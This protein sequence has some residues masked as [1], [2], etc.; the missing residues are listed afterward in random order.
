MSSSDDDNDSIIIQTPFTAD[1]QDNS[2]Y[3]ESNENMVITDTDNLSEDFSQSSSN[4]LSSDHEDTPSLRLVIAQWTVR[5]NV[6]QSTVNDLLHS[7]SIFP[8][9]QCLPKDART[10]LNTPTMVSVK[11]VKGGIYHHFSIK[12]ENT[13][14]MKQ[15]IENLPSILYF[16]VGIDGL[17]ITNNPVSQLWPIL[18]YFSNI[19]NKR[20]QVF[21]IGAIYGKS[22]PLDSNEFVNKI[23]DLSINGFSFNEKH[24]KVTFQGLICDAPAKSFVLNIKGHNGKNSC[25][26]CLNVG[27][28]MN[29][30]VYFPDLESPLRTYTDFLTYKDQT[31]HNGETILTEIPNFNVIDSTPFDYMHSI[32]IGLMKKLLFWTGIH[33]HRQSLPSNLISVLDEKLTS[34][35]S[36]ISF[37]FQRKPDLNSRRH[38]LRDA[39][40]WKATE[41]RECLLYTGIVIF[42]NILSKEVYEHF[43]ELS[44][45]IRILLTSNTDEVYINYSQQLLKHFVGTFASIYVEIYMSLNVHS[46]LHLVDDRRKYGTLNDC[47]AFPFESFMQPL[48][49]KIRSGMKPLQQLACRFAEIRTNQTN[50]Q[51]NINLP[52]P[53]NARCP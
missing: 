6:P 10:L 39:N 35:S 31:F 16:M 24:I 48:K 23:K 1:Q 30:R 17:P 13:D 4:S 37:K 38:P 45:A 52:G 26:R 18:G 51:T 28:W 50:K 8:E 19:G 46:I 25:L 7:I 47:S 9:F 53:I 21:I 11:D 3:S 20:P 44:L 42:N 36:Y 43:L 14:L 33:K 15:I 5:C 22:K 2:F 32:C 27:R 41:L 12:N 40:R 34:L 49:K 29:N